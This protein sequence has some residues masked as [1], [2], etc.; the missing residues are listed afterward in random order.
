MPEG[1][2]IS[3]AIFLVMNNDY[4][5]KRKK[6]V[7]VQVEKEFSDDI[8]FF[9]NRSSFGSNKSIPLRSIQ[10]LN[11]VEKKFMA[12]YILE[13]AKKTDNIL[14]EQASELKIAHREIK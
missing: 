3:N 12:K 7:Q 1:R 9:K 14:K 13:R 5:E 4:K 6:L 10:R 2:R 8:S 11:A